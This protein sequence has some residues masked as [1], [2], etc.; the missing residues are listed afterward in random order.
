MRNFEEMVPRVHHVFD[1]WPA[2]KLNN[3]FLTLQCCMNEVIECNGDNDYRIVHMKKERLERDGRLPRSIRMT[4]TLPW[5]DLLQ[6]DNGEDDG[7]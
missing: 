3:V 2:H 4:Q 7:D 6:D 5:E 1:E